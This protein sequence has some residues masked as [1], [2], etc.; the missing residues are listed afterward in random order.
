MSASLLLRHPPPICAEV[1]TL[2]TQHIHSLVLETIAEKLPPQP[3]GI[4]DVDSEN[5]PIFDDLTQKFRER[6]ASSTE[7][8][9]RAVGE[10]FGDAALSFTWLHA[11][12]GEHGPALS[13]H[14]EKIAKAFVDDLDHAFDWWRVEY[15]RLSD[16]LDEI[17]QTLKREKLSRLL[18]HRRQVIELKLAAMRSG[19]D[20]FYTYR[21]L[22]TQGF[23]PSYAFP[24][25]AAT[26]S[27][28]QSEDAITRDRAMALREFAP[29]NTIYYGGHRYVVTHARPMIRL[30][31]P[32]FE[33]LL[34][35][36]Q[37]QAAYIEA[38]AK[39]AACSRCGASLTTTH[40]NEHALRMPDMFARARENITSEEE[41]RTRL[42]YIISSHCQMGDRVAPYSITVNGQPVASMTYEHNGRMV[43]VNQ[44]TR[45][46]DLGDGDPG[47][48]LCGAC[49]K[50]LF[51]SRAMADHAGTDGEGGDGRC[52]REGAAEAI[53]RGVQIFTDARHDVVSLSVP[54][55]DEVGEEQQH[56]FYTSLLHAL[57]RGVAVALNMAEGEI[58]G[59]LMPS[60]SEELPYVAVIYEQSEGGAG[61]VQAFCDA[62]KL[63]EIAGRACEILHD[64]TGD[65]DDGDACEHACYECL[66]SFYNQ[67]D[68]HLLDRQVVLPFLRGLSE[69]AVVPT[70]DGGTPG[71][72]ALLSQCGS[73]FE[74]DILREIHRRGIPLP[75]AGQRT[76]YDGE[77]PI[78][79]TD[80]F[81]GPRTIVFVDGSP[82]HLDYVQAGDEGKRKRLKALGYT[83]VVFPTDAEEWEEALSRLPR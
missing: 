49:N 53:V 34:V 77:E 75:D 74:R 36:P 35:C 51:G 43:L 47:F 6:V 61:A 76:I 7:P 14:A 69:A 41:E 80:L 78:A 28:F 81:Y 26:V 5:Y 40:P 68:H 55:L 67:R 23:L 52:A 65:A 3:E 25:Q 37:C 38:E 10:A 62:E 42:G 63:R 48:A 20:D 24:A 18:A 1:C 50:W 83:V 27:F 12:P 19:R 71:L 82:H 46:A 9:V 44:G 66:C 17:N 21:Y 30:D 58:G 16:E 32:A 11:D 54:V 8:I 2:I 4:V 22:G 72:D 29:G 64:G 79:R 56:A 60:G 45:Q 73:G 31:Q 59:T 15:R 13:A 57:L 39:R 70:D 33:S